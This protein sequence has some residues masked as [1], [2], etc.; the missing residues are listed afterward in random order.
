MG[1][2]YGGRCEWD[3]DAG[4]SGIGGIWEWHRGAGGSGIGGQMGVG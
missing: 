2:G 4:A 3:R 1:V